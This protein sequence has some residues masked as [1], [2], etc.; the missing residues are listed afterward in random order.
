M[1]ST[2]T[3]SAE[4]QGHPAPHQ[5]LAQGSASILL[6]APWACQLKPSTVQ[7]WHLSPL[8]AMLCSLSA[9]RLHVGSMLCKVQGARGLKLAWLLQEHKFDFDPLDVTKIW[10]ENLFPLQPVG[11]M[12]LNQNPSN[13]FNENEQLAFSPALVVP[14]EVQP[15]AIMAAHRCAWT[16]CCWADLAME[17]TSKAVPFYLSFAR[18]PVS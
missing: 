17:V 10:P 18:D 11:R 4:L 14:G 3:S 12:V 1:L 2:A 6:P 7:Q 13:F 9:L 8:V 15:C 16:C 5:Q